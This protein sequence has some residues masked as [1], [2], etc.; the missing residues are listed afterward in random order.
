M[1]SGEV[2]TKEGGPM[3]PAQKYYPS[4]K[5]EGAHLTQKQYGAHG[6]LRESLVL[7]GTVNDKRFRPV[8]PRSEIKSAGSIPVM[9]S[10]NLEQMVK[11]VGGDPR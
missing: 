2:D 10:G 8:S 5:G 11:Q 1:G 9:A 4:G 7:H 3:I 6:R